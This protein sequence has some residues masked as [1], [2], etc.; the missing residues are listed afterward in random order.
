MLCAGPTRTPAPGPRQK[1]VEA[2][3]AGK[4]L[5]AFDGFPAEAP[6]ND[7]KSLRGDALRDSSADHAE[8]HHAD[9]PLPREHFVAALP[10]R[11]PLLFEVIGHAPL[12]R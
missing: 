6:P 1:G 9:R 7:R 3:H 11:R 2:R 10:D 4:Y 5:D 12:E 8:S